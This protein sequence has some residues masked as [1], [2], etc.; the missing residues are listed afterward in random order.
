MPGEDGVLGAAPPASM[1]EATWW[2]V[3]PI[4]T[5]LRSEAKQSNQLIRSIEAGGRRILGDESPGT[6]KSRGGKQLTAYSQQNRFGSCPEH[7]N[8]HVR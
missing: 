7:V 6:P 8:E 4:S 5:G 1:V 3:R 2:T